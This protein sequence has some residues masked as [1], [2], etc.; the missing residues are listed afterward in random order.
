M[1]WVRTSDQKHRDQ[2]LR[3]AGKDAALFWWVA[4][5]ECA[6]VNE[7]AGNDGV[8]TPMMV[9][10]A[11]HL[12][13]LNDKRCVSA[14]VVSGLL[15]DAITVR[16][17]G[18]CIDRGGDKLASPDLF[19]HEWWEHLLPAEGKHDGVKGSNEQRRKA[20]NRDKSLVARVR[21]RD[22]DL[23]RYCGVE[24]VDSSGPRKNHRLSR[25]L[26]HIDP[27]G[28]STYENLAVSCKTDN[29][30]KGQHKPE[31]AGMT[32]WAPGTTAEMIADG[33]AVAVQGPAGS[34]RVSGRAPETAGTERAEDPAAEPADLP[35]S[36]ERGRDS[37]PGR[38]GDGPATG[39]GLHVPAGVGTGP[40]P[41]L[42]VS[43][44]DVPVLTPS[45]NG[46]DH[47]SNGDST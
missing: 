2:A 34:D 29:G 20:L 14:L 12:Y 24:T 21:K 31:D 9:D 18:P 7:G 27:W 35:A 40:G 17:C 43:E 19:I 32:L 25:Q 33:T 38:N 6:A 5:H 26:D 47:R 4:V 36:R 22:K 42:I 11:A 30:R 39:S 3:N 28:E 8:L 16:Q 10:D 41:A 15:H 37:G 44:P 45:T 23:C 13:K 46:N 1:T